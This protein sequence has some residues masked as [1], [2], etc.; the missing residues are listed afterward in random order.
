MINVSRH[1]P[2]LYFITVRQMVVAGN[3]IKIPLMHF[4]R[5]MWKRKSYKAKKSSL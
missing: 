5:N 2:T 4:V 1:T 3:Y